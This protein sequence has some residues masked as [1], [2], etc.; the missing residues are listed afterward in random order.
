MKKKQSSKKL[1]IYTEHSYDDH[2]DFPRPPV[3]TLNPTDANID[4][5]SSPHSEPNGGLFYS[6]EWQRSPDRTV[7]EWGK[8]SKRIAGIKLHDLVFIMAKEECNNE[9]LP[10]LWDY[11]GLNS[12][13][14]R[15][16]FPKW[17]SSF[18]AN[19]QSRSWVWYW[20]LCR[21]TIFEEFITKKNQSIESYY[22]NHL[23]KIPLV[24]LYKFRNGKFRPVDEKDMQSPEQYIKL[25]EFEEYLKEIGE[26]FLPLPDN[27][28][29][30]TH[31]N[32]NL[33]NLIRK[34]Q[35]EIEI[36]YRA[37][38]KVGFYT[39]VTDAD[40][41]MQKAALNEFNKKENSFKVIKTEHLSDI[42]MYALSPSQEKRDFIGGLLQKIVTPEFGKIGKHK[43][44]DVFKKLK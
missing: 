43:L 13:N 5:F 4:A 19:R 32:A 9:I 26:I 39:Y 8:D 40:K 35:P 16:R 7:F 20:L 6:E 38:K 18:A 11:S 17:E 3:H 24:S 29:S 34:V 33:N 36:L 25:G 1:T 12:D 30:N 10:N 21:W 37:I 14:R 41:S 28:Y 27:F 22:F 23:K 15:R 44:F 31:G 42:N 2:T